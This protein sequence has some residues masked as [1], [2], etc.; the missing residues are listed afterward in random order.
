MTKFINRKQT[1]TKFFNNLANKRDFWIN[2]NSSF[3]SD[4]RF[5]MKFLTGENI[6]I[7]DIGC[8]TGELLAYLKPNKGL[9]IDLSKKMIEIANK[10][11]KSLN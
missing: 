5:Y 9:G 2:K 7:L 6:K 3:Y 1:I 4:D 11:S 10:I 8:G